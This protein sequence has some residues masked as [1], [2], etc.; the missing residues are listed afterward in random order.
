MP[1]WLGRPS[2]SPDCA[3]QWSTRHA[4]SPLD[5]TLARWGR[6]R[7]RLRRIPPS[8]SHRLVI[9]LVRVE[10]VTSSPVMRGS[11]SMF[12]QTKGRSKPHRIKQVSSVKRIIKT[13]LIGASIATVFFWRPPSKR[14]CSAVGTLTADAEARQWGDPHVR[15]VPGPPPPSL[16]PS[17]GGRFCAAS[18][19]MCFFVV[20]KK[21]K[22]VRESG[23][24]WELSGGKGGARRDAWV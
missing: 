8:C 7:V 24:S 13:T 21:K 17:C 15:H 16:R 2:F 12:K 18:S 11:V 23:G 9:H 19:G 22:G 5:G 14:L 4:M 1:G 6:A 3:N 20:Q 10:N